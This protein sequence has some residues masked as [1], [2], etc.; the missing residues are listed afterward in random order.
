MSTIAF[1]TETRGLDWWDPDQRAFLV[2]WAT[3]FGQS[4]A[5]VNDGLAMQ[6]F[7]DCLYG[8][9]TVI[10]HNLPFDVH[11]LRESCGIDLLS[12]GKK[13]IDTNNLARI[14]LP[15]R[16]FGV[17]DDDTTGYKLKALAASLVDRDAKDS[18]DAIKELAVSHGIKLKDVGGYY[19]TWK[20]AP[21]EMEHY[22]RED[23]RLTLAVH[24]KLAARLPADRAQV[25]DVERTLAPTLIAAEQRGVALDQSKVE[26]LHEEYS[27][28]AEET[29]ERV[30]K[31]LGAD[32]LENND[33]MAEALQA[34]GVP[35]YRTTDT[36]KIA[37]HQFALNEFADEFPVLKDLQDWRTANKFLS[38]YIEPMLG[39]ETVHCSFRQIGAWTGRMSCS[40]PNMQNIPARAGNE[41]REMFVPR[42]GYCF[43]VCDY[44]SIEVR[45][46]AH[47]LNDPGYRALIDRGLDPHAW[48]AA[49]IWGGEME[50]Y[51][52]GTKGEKLRADAKNVLFAIVYGAGAPRVG[53]ML[54]LDPGPPLGP[55]AWAVQRGYKKAS[56]PSHPAAKKLIAT[57]KASLPG[58]IKL[59]KD[60]ITPAVKTRGYVNTIMG[61]RQPVNKDKVYVGLNA[62]IQG[63]AADI[64]KQ[65][66]NHV[67]QAVKHLDAHPVLFVHDELVLET[68]IPHAEEVLA[69]QKAAMAEAYDL[70]PALAVT[71]SICMN[72]YSEGK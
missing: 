71:G 12:V 20:A 6:R 59:T 39:R 30:V 21:A 60:R 46:L 16:G 24:E 66:A 68:P 17:Q 69:L 29:H 8:A 63:S 42:P 56:D 33:A 13:L 23:A 26:P 25:W 72:N 45:L 43:V 65:G 54:G 19:D 50:D 41:V 18:E 47:Y 3:E 57:V 52:K 34:H 67:A 35:L 32:A 55:N 9:D 40:R 53:D 4:V 28:Q 27:R 64:F 2:S 31:T 37:T 48:M 36:G 44:D 22:A 7:R 15:E 51:L 14:V 1:D 49:N 38:T 70:S 62:L 61:R 11:Q 10:A 58:Y 5:H